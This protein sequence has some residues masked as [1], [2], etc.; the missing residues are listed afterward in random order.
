MVQGPLR[1]CRS[2]RSGASGYLITAH[3]L[4]ASLL[5]LSRW[6]C[7][8][9][10]NQNPKTKN[11]LCVLL[12]KNI[13]GAAY[14]RKKQIKPKKPSD[15]H[16]PLISPVIKLV[17]RHP[18]QKERTLKETLGSYAHHPLSPVMN[19][20]IRHP[21]SPVVKVGLG[22]SR[23]NADSQWNPVYNAFHRIFCCGNE[24]IRR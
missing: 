20:I 16:N 1:E 3:H 24:T 19:L 2:I 22:I 11:H 15:A 5:Y 9:I 4:Y 12:K 21:L 13:C 10:T 6:L 8:G 7:G 18:S 14:Q 23:T 17:I